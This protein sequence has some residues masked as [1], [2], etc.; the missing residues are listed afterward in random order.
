VET[1]SEA[2][3]DIQGDTGLQ[4]RMGDLKYYELFMNMMLNVTLY[5]M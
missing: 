5:S 3:T 1:A 4:H 2:W